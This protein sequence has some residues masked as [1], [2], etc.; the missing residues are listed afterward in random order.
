MWDHVGMEQYLWV[1][2]RSEL[3][4]IREL[5]PDRLEDLTE[6]ELLALHKRVRRARNKH[7]SNYRRGAA[8]KVK[9]AGGRGAAHSASDKARARAYVF[10]EALGIISDE[11]AHKA[12]EQAEALRDERLAKARAGRSP[13]PDVSVGSAPV[14]KGKGR[15]VPHTKTTGG[16]KR[17]ASSKAK[18]SRRQAKK[19][20]R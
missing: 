18:G 4:L 17:D 10:E 16:I 19:D 2:K 13:G 5:E 1:L 8:K 14:G 7:T 12:H 11:L 20:A 6:D 3:D 9:K 15:T